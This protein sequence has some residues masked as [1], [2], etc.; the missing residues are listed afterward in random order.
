MNCSIK[1]T[2]NILLMFLV[3]IKDIFIMKTST[4]LILNVLHNCYQ[5]G[6]NQCFYVCLAIDMFTYS[7]Y[8]KICIIMLNAVTFVA[9]LCIYIIEFSRDYWLLK[10]FNYNIDFPNNNLNN[11]KNNSIYTS[12][13]ENLNDYNHR[14]YS[15]YKYGIYLYIINFIVSSIY[16]IVYR[17]DYKTIA[18]LL[19]FGICGF[20]RLYD[21]YCIV[22]KSYTN[23]LAYSIFLKEYMSFNLIN[24]NKIINNNVL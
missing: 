12:L 21:G 20:Q 2:K 9:I 16:L 13:F 18:S 24:K 11:Y 19:F 14:L 23:K 5:A 22:K 17:F 3:A 1:K 10:Y 15:R 6:C 4:M 7:D 8:Y